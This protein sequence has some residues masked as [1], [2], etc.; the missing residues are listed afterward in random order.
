[1]DSQFIKEVG[2]KGGLAR[3]S[4]DRDLELSGAR[5]PMLVLIDAQPPDLRFQ[6][7]PWYAE[8]RGGAGTTGYPPMALGESRL[9]LLHFRICQPRKPLVRPRRP[10]GFDFQPALLDYEGV[11]FT[12]DDCA[13]HYVLQFANVPGPTVL[14]QLLDRKS[15]V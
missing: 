6:R 8:F 9:D 12:E 15:V 10:R 11:R 5:T 14:S 4:P 1:M 2:K 13:F 7:L 3:L